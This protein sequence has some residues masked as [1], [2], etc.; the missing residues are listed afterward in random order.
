MDGSR[1]RGREGREGGREGRE[2]REGGKRGRKGG[3][4]KGRLDLLHHGWPHSCLVSCL[5]PSAP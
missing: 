3:I 5:W 4:E 2:E 1:E